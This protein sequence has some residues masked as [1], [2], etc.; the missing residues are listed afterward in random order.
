MASPN[1]TT[2]LALDE[3]A[4]L[5][6]FGERVEVPS[7]FLLD[8]YFPTNPITDIFPTE[9]VLIDFHDKRGKKLAPLVHEG[10]KTGARRT[11]YTDKLTPCRIA[12]KRTLGIA[13][14]M[15]RGYG[16]QLFSGETATE[17]AVEIVM[18]DVTDIHHEIYRRKMAMAGELLTSNKYTLAYV[19]S[20]AAGEDE[21]VTEQTVSFIDTDGNIAAYTPDVMWDA[22]GA[23]ILADVRAMCRQVVEN[24]GAAVD[25]LL[26]TD[27]ADAFVKDER[28]LK[29]LDIKRVEIGNI[30]PQLMMPGVA[31]I[32]KINVDGCRL[33]VISYWET[34]TDDNGQQ[35]PY[36]PADAAVVLAPNCG[37]TLYAAVTQLEQSDNSYH[38]YEKPIVPKYIGN[39]ETDALSLMM[40]S[41]PVLAP[42]VKGCFVYAHV[43]T[44]AED[45][46]GG[47]GGGGGGSD[48]EDDE[49]P[50]PG[51]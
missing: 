25:L 29:L 48:V 21:D 26:G 39:A 49:T 42:K 19:A 8:R 44:P 36:L 17:R 46:G 37:K 16:E 31:M 32:G 23:D 45:A 47:E 11:F 30:D 13:A 41:K 14:L 27:A 1:I 9:D 24:G 3:T 50:V 28:I 20:D 2:T 7:R 43:I 10:Y 18:Q 5:L 22:E 12:P 33:N 38:T 34:Y 6:A 35:V 40:Q 4:T 51:K 15:K